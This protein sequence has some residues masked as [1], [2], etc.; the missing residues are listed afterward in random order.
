MIQTFAVGERSVLKSHQH[1][2][3]IVDIWI[4]VI[5]ELESPPARCRI[6]IFDLP[7]ACTED[8]FVEQPFRGTSQYVIAT[9]SC[10]DERKGGN[11][12]VPYRRQTRLQPDGWAFFDFKF[13]ELMNLAGRRR[14]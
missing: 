13:T 5:P 7:I 12:R 2:R 10:F 8:L 3:R 11:R 4:E 14:M 1:K 9:R 6:T